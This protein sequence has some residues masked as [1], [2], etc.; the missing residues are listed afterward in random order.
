MKSNSTNP[1]VYSRR[2]LAK[3]ALAAAPVAFFA[4]RAIPSLAA[5]AVAVAKPNSLIKGV[6]VGI[7]APYSTSGNGAD[8]ILQ[9]LVDAGISGVELQSAP[10]EGFARAGVPGATAEQNAALA[11]VNN[12]L[13]QQTASVQAARN[14]VNNATF[15]EPA[16]LPDRLKE[17]ARLELEL[18][19]ARAEAFSK[20]QASSSR[21]TPQQVQS[22]VTSQ[23][24]P[25]AGGGRGGGAGGAS[26]AEWRSTVA[27]DR[28]Q[29]LRKMYNDAGVTIYGF[30]MDSG[31][32]NLTD[33]ECDYTFNV[34]RALGANHVTMEI[35]NDNATLERNAKFAEK[36]KIYVA[37]HNHGAPNNYDAV[38]A[39][40]PYSGINMDVGH[41]TGAY[42]ATPI[43]VIE[44][45]HERIKS[46]HFK[47]KNYQAVNM[48][49]GQ[50]QTPLDEVLR[51]MSKEKYTFPATIELEYPIPAG[52]DRLAE[53]KK[54]VA[55]CR[56]A[57]A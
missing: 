49:W 6:Q 7:I 43:P 28:F 4:G 27:M 26:N 45:Y 1:N 29:Q 31:L 41:F 40:G 37:Y 14:A 17:L 34:A 10:V 56:A 9:F 3:F 24:Q 18:A 30:K 38:V 12:G 2:E 42:K 36:H 20:L 57:L 39:A 55:Y 48:P 8:G 53:A 46:M 51:L 54:C 22:I 5:D 21:F 50:G 33:A 23:Q 35:V 15:G 47:D 16:A 44:K 13:T 25:A 32:A 52:S 11:T 19:N